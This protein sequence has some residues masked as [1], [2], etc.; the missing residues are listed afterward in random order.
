[1]SNVHSNTNNLS[2]QAKRKLLIELLQKKVGQS[3]TLPLSYAQ[4]RLW[5]LYQLEP[6]SPAYNITTP[7]RLTGWLNIAALEQSLNEIVRRHEALRTTFV[8][9]EGQ[10]FQRIAPALNLTLPLIDLRQLSLEERNA[11]A[12]RIA[13]K[14][15]WQPFKLEQGLL[16]R[17]SLLQ[18]EQTE[19]LLLFTM[20]HIV[21]DG[22]SIGVLT[23]EL[24]TLYEAFCCGQPSP[25]PELPIQ[26]ADFAVWQQQWLQGQVLEAQLSYWKQQLSDNLPTLELPTDRVRPVVPTFA[27]STQS[28]IISQVLTTE[29]EALSQ[30]EKVTLFMTLL[31][32][33]QILLHWYT[34]QDDIVVGTDVA[35]R[36][37]IETEELIGFFV[38]QLVLRTDLSGNPTF[39]ELLQ[40]VRQVTL[41]AYAHQD[42]P[43][44]KLVEVLNPGRYLNRMP[45]FQVK[46]VLQNTPMPTL[47]LSNLTLEPLAVDITTAQLDL[48]LNIVKTDQ[49]LMAILEYSTDLFEAATIDRM[50][51]HLE[52]LL[53]QVVKQPK[54]RLNTL[55]EILSQ[56]DK[57]KKIAQEKDYRNTIQ[58]K[59]IN[60]KRK[61]ASKPKA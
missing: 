43:F 48:L 35:N 30:R 61:T 46:I 5:F 15:A 51:E 31:A 37:H 24:T 1:M 4:Q 23:R 41:G 42:L 22:W 28:L 57:Q 56:L 17:C 55:G 18:L 29:L 47:E 14:E 58:E 9:V 38:N 7:V 36:N 34:N 49:G 10:P 12:L 60:I 3:R 59:L 16:L 26:Y 52:T 27:G 33:F 20:H 40:R 53:Q 32:V 25:L 45:L 8:L 19:Y 39:E 6:D 21:S 13:K 50:L 2:R 11:E 44:N 54:A